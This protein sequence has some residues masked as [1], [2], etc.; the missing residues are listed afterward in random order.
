MRHNDARRLLF[1]LGGGGGW[2]REAGGEVIANDVLK[3]RRVIE[4]QS[5]GIVVYYKINFG[6]LLQPICAGEVSVVIVVDK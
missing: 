3:M 2:G 4:F 6:V 5:L 1:F